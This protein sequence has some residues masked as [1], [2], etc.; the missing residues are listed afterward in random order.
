MPL[1]RV[2]ERFL[3]V[4]VDYL[5]YIPFDEAVP[6]SVRAQTS[7]MENSP[8]S[9]A[10]RALTLL[11]GRLLDHRSPVRPT[12]GSQFLFRSLLTQAELS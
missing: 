5:G 12:G 4:A 7:L 8:G 10:A 1:A 9:S 11:A 3:S 2:A 6:R